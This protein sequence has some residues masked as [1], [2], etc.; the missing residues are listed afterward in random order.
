MTIYIDLTMETLNRRNSNLTSNQETT[1]FNNL[2]PEPITFFLL[3][4]W[5]LAGSFA[6][7]VPYV[8]TFASLSILNQD[9]YEYNQNKIY[10]AAL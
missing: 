6:F 7:V 8:Q 5:L 1:F 4:Y 10:Y 2:E 3:G 9:T